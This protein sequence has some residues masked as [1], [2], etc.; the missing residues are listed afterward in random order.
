M[1]VNVEEHPILV[2]IIGAS[3]LIIAAVL[4]YLGRTGVLSG[5]GFDYTGIVRSIK[6]TPISD[7]EV[8][9]TEDQRVPQHV[10]TDSEGVFH[11]RLSKITQNV[12]LH[13]EAEG[14]QTHDI[15]VQPWRIGAEEILLTPVTKIDAPSSVPKTQDSHKPSSCSVPPMRPNCAQYRVP[16]LAERIR[17]RR[18]G[19][20]G[21]PPHL[22]EGS[23]VRCG[24]GKHALLD[25]SCG[26]PSRF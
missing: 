8:S 25:L 23:P 20:R 17:S 18:S 10:R 15:V 13:V 21:L 19:A 4:S 14:Y 16:D 22:P 5:S 11:V 12:R 24:Q 26:L 2:A 3:A 7:A 6:R 1:P 9:I